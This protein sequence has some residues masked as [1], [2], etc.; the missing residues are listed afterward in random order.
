[1]NRAFGDLPRS[2]SLATFG[3]V[4]GS[5]AAGTSHSSL[6][7]RVHLPL[8][9]EQRLRFQAP[10]ETFILFAN[11]TSSASSLRTLA[12]TLGFISGQVRTDSPF[13][14]NFFIHT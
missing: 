14:L 1:M 11:W 4:F 9:L 13:E 8:E 12:A 7:V 6:R 5:I 2:D 3:P 10:P